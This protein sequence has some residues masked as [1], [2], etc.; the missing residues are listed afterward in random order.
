MNVE[1]KLFNGA[2]FGVPRSDLLPDSL[3]SLALLKQIDVLE[4]LIEPLHGRFSVI[5]LKVTIS[6]L[7]ALGEDLAIVP[8]IHNHLFRCLNPIYQLVDS[9]TGVPL[10]EFALEGLP[11][12]VALVRI[13]VLLQ[14]N[15]AERQHWQRVH[16]ERL[17]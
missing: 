8:G 7:K 11:E 2:N 10:H 6:F 4:Q 15:A 17:C 9:L 16:K 5:E 14:G 13:L 12:L 3:A 1:D